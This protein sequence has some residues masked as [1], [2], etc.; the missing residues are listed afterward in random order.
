MPLTTNGM[1]PATAYMQ[2][3]FDLVRSKEAATSYLVAPGNI[4][5]L[6]DANAKKLYEKSFETMT[7][8]DLVQKETTNQN[9][10]NFGMT[11]QGL[12]D[13]DKKEISEMIAIALSQYNPHIPKKERRNN[14]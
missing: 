10:S 11:R 3:S 14:E 2:I 9:G 13:E 4:V 5:Y 12:T 1:Q 7:E 6:L 8:F